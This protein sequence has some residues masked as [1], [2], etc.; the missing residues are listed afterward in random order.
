MTLKMKDHHGNDFFKGKMKDTLFE[1]ESMND[2][3]T[4]LRNTLKK[5]T[6]G[7]EM[8]RNYLYN[9]KLEQDQRTVIINISGR[10]FR[11]KLSNFLQYPESRLGQICTAT[12]LEEIQTLCD[13]FVPG[14]VPILYFDRNPQ[15]FG[16]ILDV[17]RKNEVHICERH[18][19]LVVQNE[20]RYWGLEQLLLQ[21]CCS[22]KYYPDNARAQLEMDEDKK[23]KILFDER[24]KDENFGTDLVGRIRTTMWDFIEYPETSAFSQL[25]HSASIFFIF[26]STFV[27][28]AES[29]Y[30][31][32]I[33]NNED[34]VSKWIVLLMKI[35]KFSDS[36]CIMF[37]TTEITLR[38]LFC[39][40]KQ[41][42]ITDPLNF[43]DFLAIAPFFLALLLEEFQDLE[44]IGKAGKLIRIMRLMRILRIF[45]MVRHF[46][47]LQSLFYTIYQAYKV[48]GILKGL[49]HCK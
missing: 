11:T 33:E 3:S 42:F 44:I 28:L 24:E 27:F 21:P 31:T 19:S 9:K 4:L 22:L 6:K 8:E 30:E 25:F 40:N 29:S 5:S 32:E 18:C 49:A 26:L 20:F 7:K 41:K 39:P 15:H 37:F 16:N 34:E 12:T 43:V 38:F 10:E 45:K 13:G 23:E 48:Y 1:S 2:D 14:L 36:I 46:V 17:Y 47:G 35:L